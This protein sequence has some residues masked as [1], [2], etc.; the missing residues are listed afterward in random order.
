MY[1]GTYW[2]L[3]KRIRNQQEKFNK[4]YIIMIFILEKRH[5]KNILNLNM[6]LT[7]GTSYTWLNFEN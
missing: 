6:N 7:F 3:K 2:D 4:F 5:G 1:S